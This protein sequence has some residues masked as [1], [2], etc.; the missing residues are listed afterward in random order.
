MAIGSAWFALISDEE[1]AAGESSPACTET[2]RLS[3]S[4]LSG[5]KG[6]MCYRTTV[7]IFKINKR[8]PAYY[9]ISPGRAL[10]FCLITRPKARLKRLTDYG[11]K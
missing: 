7:K 9:A 3:V 8:A 10:S 11:I 4:A 2:Q 1:R 6:V 5:R